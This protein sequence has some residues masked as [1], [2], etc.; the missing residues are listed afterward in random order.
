MNILELMHSIERSLLRSLFCLLPIITCVAPLP[1]G[2]R[3]FSEM[4]KMTSGLLRHVGVV[5]AGGVGFP[6]SRLQVS[7]NYPMLIIGA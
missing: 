2:N 4:N 6:H 3:V 1:C 7:E 5:R